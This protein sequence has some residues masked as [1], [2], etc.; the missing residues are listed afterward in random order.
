MNTDILT[1][2][3][4]PDGRTLCT[5][6]IQA[7]IDACAASGGGRVTVPAGVYFSGTIWLR[8]NV[9]LHLEHNSVIKG[10]DDMDD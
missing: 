2:G 7:A 9:E 6:E 8:S 4:K 5:K 1:Y 3:A 10:S